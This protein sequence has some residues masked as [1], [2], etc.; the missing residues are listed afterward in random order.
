MPPPPLPLQGERGPGAGGGGPLPPLA[1]AAPP[2]PTALL[3]APER[4][5]AP[6][7]GGGATGDQYAEKGPPR[8]SRSA[9]VLMK[10][11]VLSS[12]NV[13]RGR[14]SPRPHLGEEGG[15]LAAGGRAAAV[16]SKAYPTRR[17]WA[18]LL[19]GRGR[20]S[21]PGRALSV[22]LKP[23]G[24]RSWRRRCPQLPPRLPSSPSRVL[25][26]HAGSSPGKRLLF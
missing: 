10:R 9:P 20:G 21:D 16:A 5:H 23:P 11:L 15:T 8:P 4:L 25:P 13:T 26:P 19:E 18:P 6:S 7:A 2:G 22:V 12:C 17:P 1:P 3:W 14:F 24:R